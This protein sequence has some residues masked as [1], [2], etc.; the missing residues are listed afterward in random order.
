[1]ATLQG[2][3]SREKLQKCSGNKELYSIG[4]KKEL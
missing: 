4:K 2:V 1:M 3:S